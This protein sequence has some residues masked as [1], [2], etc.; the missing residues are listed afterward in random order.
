[1]STAKLTADSRYEV[2]LPFKD[3]HS[4][5]SSNY[6]ISRNRLIK[7]IEKLKSEKLFEAYGNIFKDW[8]SEGIIEE[9]S[10]TEKKE[11]NHYLP[12][13]PVIKAHG[14][15]TIGPVFDA[16]SCKKG[17]PSLNQC[18][19]KGPNL[20]EL[21][22]SALNRFREYEIG[23]VSDVKKAFL[24]IGINELDRDYLRFLWLDGGQIKIFRHRRV[25]FGLACSPFLLAAVIEL[26]L[27]RAIEKSKSENSTDW[28]VNSVEKL[29]DSFYV[30]NCVT[31]VETISEREKFEHEA[32]AI[33]ATGSFDLRG[34]EYTGDC[35]ESETTLVLGLLWNKRKEVMSINP[36]ILNIEKPDKV[37]KRTMLSAAHR[38]FDPIGF[39]APVTL[40]PKL[41]LQELWSEK[42]E[43]DTVIEDKR[44]EIFLSWLENL[45]LLKNV[46]IPRK[47]GKG[48]LTLHMFSDASGVA[49]AATVF[50][51]ADYLG[52][53]NVQLISA[54]SRIAPKGATI[55]RLELMAA[56]IGVRLTDATLKSMTREVNKVTYWTDSSTVLAWIGRDIQW[57]TF[58]HNRVKEIRALSRIEDWQHVPGEFNPADLPSRG[59]TPSQLLESKWW[60]GP[61]W[62]YAQQEEWPVSGC[63]IN[64]NE[65]EK[66]KKKTI[67]VQMVNKEEIQLD[68]STRFSSYTKL[69]RFIALALR[70][71]RNCRTRIQS[72]KTKDKYQS[73][74]KQDQENQ[75]TSKE[76]EIAEIRLMQNLQKVMFDLKSTNKL[77]SLK[78]TVNEN[79]LIVV[80]TKIF[81]REDNLNFLCPVVLDNKHDVIIL[82]VR[83]THEKLGH[84]GS[85]TVMSSLREKFW[86]IS[87]RRIV[88]SV[89]SKCV[90]CQRQ[91]AKHADCESPPLPTN[92]VRDALVFE[93]TGVDFAGPLFLRGG[94]KAWIVI[95]TCAVYRAVH[96]E[97]ASSLS[98]DEFMDCFRMFIARRG[99]PKYMHSDNGT[100]FKGLA[101]AL[102]RLNWEIIAKRTSTME[103]NWV[104]NPPSAPWW[105]G[106]WERLIGV[107]KTILR[108]ILGRAS[109]TY[110]SMITTLCDA[111]AIV[112]SRPLTYVSEDPDDLKPLTPSMFLQE[113]REIGVPDL[114]MLY[115]EKLNKKLKYR[116][117]IFNDLRARFRSEYLG[118]LTLKNSKKETRKINIGDVVLI[119]DDNLKRIDWPLALVVDSI[120]GRDNEC[121]VFVLK[122]KKGILKRA[123]QR[124]YPLEVTS[125]ETVNDLRAKRNEKQNKTDRN[126]NVECVMNDNSQNECDKD[127]IVITRSGRI[128]KKPIRYNN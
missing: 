97:L 5:V 2:R 32:K 55:P 109:L 117:K 120:A 118:Q 52:V 57:G 75:L 16:S 89:I 46:E 128:S 127:E 42:V 43:W 72:R 48:V 34:W 10:K 106:W 77:S 85:L 67:V 30:D 40:L 35:T 114:D 13:R 73:I 68:I 123:I 90:I 80:K 71:V 69:L 18:L 3:N 126:K 60:R 108:K 4:V 101:N 79:G 44:G 15:T 29:R 14:T 98:T 113:I 41:L 61:K 81:N 58:V 125:K 110:E 92:R 70:F 50:V 25:V 100:N 7:T 93:V 47:I 22:P 45:K 26:I 63:K 102:K 11:S 54:R 27:I 104:F 12:H 66:E 91:K 124:I 82:L 64:E 99:R 88:K 94:E 96:F 51:R 6:E 1:M 116:Q 9:V 112:N 17:S 65:V 87:A 84:A 121:R 78:T 74:D 107:L 37:S 23:V 115:T 31:S 19:E 8:L 62:L 111:E 24:Q 28:S 20:I 122:T 33:M 59:C 56:T 39:S 83:E 119:G 21:V 103:I 38:V 105:G 76:I 49:Y 53:I 95:F 36:A 86:I